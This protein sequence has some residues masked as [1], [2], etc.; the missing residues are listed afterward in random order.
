MRGPQPLKRFLAAYA[1]PSLLIMAW[2]V[3]PLI[4]GTETLFLRD[5]FNTHLEKKWVQAEAMRSGY[6]PLIDPYRDGGQ[7]HLGNPNSVAFYPDNL[8]FLATPF[9][10]AFNAHFWLHF[11]LAP[12]SGFWLARAWGLRREA[13]WAAGV[14]LAT[15][16]FFLSNLGFYNLV[17]GTAWT[18][19]LVALSLRLAAPESRRRHFVL[20]GLVW[21]LILLAGDPMTGLIAL[22]LAGSAVVFRWGLRGVGW[23]RL[24]LSLGLGSLIAAPQWI[25]FLRILPL[26]FRGV[27]RYSEVAATAASWHPLTAIEWLLPFVFG[28]P[29]LVFWGQRFHGGDLPLFPTLYPGLLALVLLLGSGRPAS[30]AARWAWTVMGIGWFLALGQHNV[31]VGWLLQLP[32]ANLLRLPVKFWLLVAVG[33]ALL[34]GIGFERLVADRRDRSWWRALGL[35][36]ALFLLLWAVLGGAADEAPAWLGSLLRDSLTPEGL[37]AERL[38][39]AGLCLLSLAILAG[40]AIAFRLG[41]RWPT[42]SGAALVAAQAGLQLVLL[43]P[44][45]ATDAV[46][47]YREPSPLLERVPADKP[48]AH[49]KA[50]GLFGAVEVRP[51]DYPDARLL[52]LQR[53][54]F[55]ELYPAAGILW[56]RRYEF[57]RSAEGLDAF[58]TRALSQSFE[59]LS[60]ATR[61]RLLAA[62]GVGTL[63]LG[64][65]L[66]DEA[67]ELVT[68]QHRERGVAGEVLVYRLAGP[69]PPAVFAGNVLRAPHLNAALA[70]MTRA[71]F[72]PRTTAVLPGDGPTRQGPPGEVVIRS[73]TPEA[74]ELEV[75]A[76]TAGALVIQRAFLPLYRA[77]A[78]GRRLPIVAANIHR[79]GIELPA[80]RHRVRVWADR[81]P[82][83]IAV[84]L[85]VVGVLSLPLLAR[86][87]LPTRGW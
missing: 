78:D 15:G 57:S 28:R 10:W 58:L 41:R 29:D 77:T 45:L 54:V 31:A 32:G 7:P 76:P 37:N 27:Q 56:G 6:L 69:A 53:Q 50:S 43:R 24:V 47:I 33:G 17:A 12:C 1:A 71:H 22:L 42:L 82:L 68:L 61:V 66:D 59:V 13:S 39:W 49:G 21:A 11:L 63:V 55:R 83:G 80:G 86:R 81:R 5:V 62:A 2:S 52:W 40:F 46:A 3:I 51:R 74:L 4:R 38:R 34:C 8:L 60:D 75:R 79:L 23:L 44:A 26:S 35:L 64:R 9:F 73:S 14:C 87:L 67:G 65:E 30:R 18:P 25:E 70:A 36:A 48:V 72:D 19:A 85:A 84:A 20:T 16:G